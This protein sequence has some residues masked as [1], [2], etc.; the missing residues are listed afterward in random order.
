MKKIMIVI[1]ATI[2]SFMTGCGSTPI[3]KQL[4]D[5]TYTIYANDFN[6]PIGSLG[7]DTAKERFNK[8][9]LQRCPNGFD[10]L[11]KKMRKPDLCEVQ[12]DIRCKAA[13]SEVK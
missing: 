3:V 12:G 5:N 7:C 11:N 1:M 13:S 10:E 9:A 2:V 4:S 6:F 8:E